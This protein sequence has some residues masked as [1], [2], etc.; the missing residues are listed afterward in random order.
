[1]CVCVCVCV[2]KSTCVHS[3]QVSCFMALFQTRWDELSKG[4]NTHLH[5]H[6]H[7]HI[8]T[9]THTH[10]H[11]HTH[12]YIYTHTH[13]STHTHTHTHLHTHTHTHTH[14]YTHTHTPTHIF[15]EGQLNV[16]F[17]IRNVNYR[18]KTKTSNFVNLQPINGSH[19]KK[20]KFCLQTEMRLIDQLDE[21]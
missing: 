10:I 5:T 3:T 20:R 15:I 2:H 16:S 6:I 1:M 4:A 21:R 14:L 12:T 13:T 17:Q 9:H 11:L 19:K 8:Y 7:T 18:I